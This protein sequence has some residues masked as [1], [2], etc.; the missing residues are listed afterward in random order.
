VKH[1]RARAQAARTRQPRRRS[2]TIV[3]AARA[4]ARTTACQL[5]M[6]T[7][8]GA[9]TH[10]VLAVSTPPL[11]CARWRRWPLLVAAGLA[12]L[13]LVVVGTLCALRV[14]A[15]RAGKQD[16]DIQ[17]QVIWNTAQGR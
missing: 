7:L 6:S 17:G 16:L 3:A 15:Y 14:D 11:A 12:L 4:A 13:W 5:T 1:P 10:P 9:S 8:T 2:A